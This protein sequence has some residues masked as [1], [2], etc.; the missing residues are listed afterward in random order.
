MTGT[1]RLDL[2]YERPPAPLNGNTRAHWRARSAA[3]RQVRA[4]V[5]CLARAA[6][7]PK[8]E[9]LTVELLWSP[10]DR[11]RRDADNLWPLLK[12]ACDALARGRK[13]WVGLELVPDDTPAYMDKRAPV[14]LSPDQCGQRGMWLVVTV[15]QAGLRASVGSANQGSQECPVLTAPTRME[16]PG[17]ATRARA[18]KN[19]DS[20]GQGGSHAIQS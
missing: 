10:G 7:I 3:T 6:G 8:A 16:P 12:V 18:S 2:P 11:R 13:D 4:D 17:A 15:R 20:A 14:I 5:A 9:H 1:Y 19:L